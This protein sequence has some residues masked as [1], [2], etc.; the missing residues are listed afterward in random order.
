MIDF[1]TAIASIPAILAIVNLLKSIGFPA[2]LS[3]LAA[4][5][6]G[7]ALNLAVWAWADYSWFSYATQ[8][9]IF[10]LA[11]AGLYDV[12]KLNAG[13]LTGKVDTVVQTETLAITTPEIP[14]TTLQVDGETR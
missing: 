10:G 8:G 5:I 4:V 14:T 2:K 9:L 3:P 7:V 11:A 12:T 1:V 13:I 6:I